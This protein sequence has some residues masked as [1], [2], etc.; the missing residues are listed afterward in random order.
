MNITEIK[1]L[2]TQ[3]EGSILSLIENFENQTDCLV[4]DIGFWHR[5]D[6]RGIQKVEM[7]TEVR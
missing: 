2:K 6:G 1:Q 5:K 4:V 3:T 7:R